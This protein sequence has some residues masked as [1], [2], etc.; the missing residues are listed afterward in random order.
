MIGLDGA[1]AYWIKQFIWLFIVPPN[2]LLTLAAFG[3]L[4]VLVRPWRPRTG[5]L[6]SLISLLVFYLLV[7]PAVSQRLMQWVEQG[8]GPAL[9]QTALATLLKSEHPPGAIVILGGGMAVDEREL[10]D[11]TRPSLTTLVRLVH[12][13]QLARWSGLPVLVS[14]GRPVGRVR[15]EAAVMAQSLGEHFSV[16][17][18]WLEEES[19]DTIDNA[20]YSSALLRK[21]GIRHVILVTEAFH[22]RRAKFSFEA[23]GLSVTPAPFAFQAEQGFAL[24]STWLPVA[25]SVAR[26]SWAL[27]EIVGRWW[28]QIRRWWQLFVPENS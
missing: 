9:S 3:A 27:H 2:G 24:Q 8:A 17:P 26:T 12:G 15:S 13:A 5:A 21:E 20:R 6:I 10:P 16:K 18:R 25:D 19:L 7:T 4:L 14:G 22:M 23:A 11:K 1:S 28:Y